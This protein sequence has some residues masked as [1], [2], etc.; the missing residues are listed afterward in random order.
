MVIIFFFLSIR[1]PTRSSRT[2]P[3]VPY[4]PLSRSPAPHKLCVGSRHIGAVGRLRGGWNGSA[5]QGSK[6]KTSERGCGRALS[7]GRGA[8]LAAGE[9]PARYGGL[10]FLHCALA[11][12][13]LR[14]RAGV[15]LT[16]VRPDRRDQIGRAAGRERVCQYV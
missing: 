11:R 6:V 13:F 8:A 1:P 12:L 5:V 2:A 3:P 7:S 10:A 15:W 16:G 9:Q 4:T 14:R